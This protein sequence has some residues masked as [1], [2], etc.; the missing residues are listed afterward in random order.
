MLEH[1][2]R[3][4]NKLLEFILTSP[5]LIKQ[6][7][8]PS[9][10]ASSL[11]DINLDTL[12][13]EYVLSCIHSG[14]VV[15]V[16]EAT[17]SY[18][19]ELAYPAMIHSPSGNSYFTLTESKVSG[20]PPNRRPPPVGV[21]KRTNFAPRSSS[22]ADRISDH[23]TASWKDERAFVAVNETIRPSKP[24]DVGVVPLLGLPPLQTGFLKDCR[25][26]TCGSQHMKYWLHLS[27]FLGLRS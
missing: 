12:S 14:G 19:R 18:Y 23:D 21:R 25:M 16:S 8:T 1:Y 26:M 2:R 17:S 5:N 6:V 7:R 22:Q 4:R 20:S 27:Y 24:V 11:A 9:G 10:P 3:D 15:D 13:A